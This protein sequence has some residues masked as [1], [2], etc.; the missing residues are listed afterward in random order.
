MLNI[1]IYILFLSLGIYFI[2][3]G[4]VPE[5]YLQKRTN[6]A[7][8]LEPVTELPTITTWIQTE[9][10]EDSILEYGRDYRIEYFIAGENNETFTEF[11]K[12]IL[13]VCLFC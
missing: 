5:K 4:E 13:V 8:Y 1:V 9:F 12:A 7:E 10:V 2:K 6:F 3:Q 11:F